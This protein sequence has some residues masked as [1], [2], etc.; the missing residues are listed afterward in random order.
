[1]SAIEQTAGHLPTQLEGHWQ[2]EEGHSKALEY[3][4]KKRSDLYKGEVPDLAVASA[5]YMANRCDL[6]LIHWQDA[7]KERI[8]WLSV[9]LA[10]TN[11]LLQEQ[12]KAMADVMALRRLSKSQE[13]REQAENAI[14]AWRKVETF[15]AQEPQP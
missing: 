11:A 10:I 6:D 14:T 2:S 15:L 12:H 4:T 1:M 8:R 13:Q 9:Q 5:V 3:V 7:A